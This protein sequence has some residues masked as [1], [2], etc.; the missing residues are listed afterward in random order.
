[1]SLKNYQK[2]KL[3]IVFVLAISIS[4]SVVLGNYILPIMLM[5]IASLLLYYLRSQLKEVLADERDLQMA[6]KA[7]TAS[8]QIFGWLAVIGMFIL[9]SQKMI[10]PFYEIIASTLSYSVLFLFFIYALI[11]RYYNKLKFFKQK[12]SYLALIFVLILFLV[13]FGIRL[14]SGED[15]WVCQNGSWQKH[16]QP[17]FSAPD[18]E[19]K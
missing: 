15:N 3:V 2:I 17:S 13:V 8:I 11:Y 19:C 9:Y 7:A 1:M 18:K 16:G 6:G 5:V 12:S 14:F 4:Q 10:N